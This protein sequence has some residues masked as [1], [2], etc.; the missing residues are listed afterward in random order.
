MLIPSGTRK[1]ANISDTDKPL[2]FVSCHQG[3]Q[4]HEF[5]SVIS[6]FHRQYQGYVICDVESWE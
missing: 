2:A 1:N 4:F 3:K 6:L 5:I